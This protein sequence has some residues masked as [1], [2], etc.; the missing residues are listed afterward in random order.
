MDPRGSTERGISAS[1]ARYKDGLQKKVVYATKKCIAWILANYVH[2]V[3][4]GASEYVSFQV[5]VLFPI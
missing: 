2:K 5:K 1:R 4:K 3:L